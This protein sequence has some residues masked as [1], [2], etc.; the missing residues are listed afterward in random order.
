MKSGKNKKCDVCDIIGNSEAGLREK[1]KYESESEQEKTKN[2]QKNE[3][4]SNSWDPGA[5]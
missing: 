5:L 4:K 3:Q 1:F 2:K